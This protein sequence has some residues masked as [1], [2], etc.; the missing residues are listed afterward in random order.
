M[1]NGPEFTSK[2]MALWAATKGVELRFI[3]PG[4]PIQNAYVESF[5]GRFREECLSEHWFTSLAHA[6]E[7][8]AEWRHD[9]NERR[10]HSSLGY[11]L[12]ARQRKIGQNH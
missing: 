10:P 1:D 11:V 5:N 12:P 2:A 3:E 7:V 8:I 6:R 9:Y 4:K